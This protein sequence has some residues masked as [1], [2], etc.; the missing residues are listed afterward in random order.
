MVTYRCLALFGLLISAA[1]GWTKPANA[2]PIKYRYVS[3]PVWHTDIKNYTASHTVRIEKGGKATWTINRHGKRVPILKDPNSEKVE[4]GAA[5]MLHLKY[6]AMRGLADLS[7]LILE[8]GNLSYKVLTP[9][10]RQCSPQIPLVDLFYR[11][12]Y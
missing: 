5:P 8:V 12:T 4:P 6:L 3:N 1:Y 2:K 7:A 10:K 9:H 11:L